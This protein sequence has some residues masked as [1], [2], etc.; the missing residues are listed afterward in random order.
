MGLK[1]PRAD[2]AVYSLP[3]SIRTS[4][5]AILQNVSN[6][7]GQCIVNRAFTLLLVIKK[8][9]E[10]YSAIVIGSLYD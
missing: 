3:P 5:T 7:T 9:E 8:F 4:G 10:A 6:N 2:G 1:M